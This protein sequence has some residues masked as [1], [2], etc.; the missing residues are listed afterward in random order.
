MKSPFKFLDSYTVHDK[1]TFFGR[2]EETDQLYELVNRNRLVLVY[3][4]SGTGKTS[5]IQCGLGNRYHNT[6]W[7]PLFIRKGHNFTRSLL[8]ALSQKLEEED[9]D[10]SNSVEMISAL[11]D[12][13]LRTVFLIFD[14]FEEIFTLGTKEEEDEFL[15]QL[16]AILDAK[17]PCRVILS[18][19]EEYLAYLYDFEKKISNFFDSRMRVER[20][21]RDNS[22]QVVIK[23]CEAFNVKLEDADKNAGILIDRVTGGKS[24]VS[25]P[26]LQVYLD[27]L[28]R[29]DFKRTYP[30]G[31]LKVEDL[32]SLEFT[33]QEINSFSDLDDVMFLF[34][35]EQTDKLQAE[36]REK[37]TNSSDAAIKTVLGEF[38][39]LEGTRIPKEK[40][41][42]Q[43][44]T[45]NNEQVEFILQGLEEARILRANE[46]VYEL[47]HDSL[48]AQIQNQRSGNEIALLEV[49]E[50]VKNTYG[51][52]DKTRTPL[53]GKQLQLIANYEQKL[54]DDAK[55]SNE[56]WAFI[57]QSRRSLLRKRLVR[58][59]L[60][61]SIIAILS[62][63]TFNNWSLYKKS[64]ED[65]RKLIDQQ[66]TA[67][68]NLG[69]FYKEKRGRLQGE[70]I[71]SRKT[72]NDIK[73][74]ARFRVFN[75]SIKNEIA[76]KGKMLDDYK[77][78]LDSLCQAMNRIIK[79]NEGVIIKSYDLTSTCTT[80]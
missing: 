47:A 3:G 51:A 18:L 33:S 15:Q 70:L 25:L 69:N 68:L 49:A 67:S 54:K 11:Y 9:K 36:F 29:E 24:G 55:L 45:L 59:S 26:N 41:E 64:Q 4:Q 42:I 17:L 61:I 73:D 46:A 31:E 1:N 28:Y 37:Y 21:S 56:E 43:K 7:L 66:V 72:L 10:L 12:T 57:K 19:R 8:N 74:D 2:D 40:N 79:E 30:N 53:N 32:P 48:A 62:F 20:M 60:I 71:E 76:Y 63:L 65:L 13:Y 75:D 50:L 52:F 58:N 77:D 5:L 27:R 16:K 44:S 38:A 22:M 35:Q 14:Q 80:E 78:R 34:L 39:T 6:D 23:S